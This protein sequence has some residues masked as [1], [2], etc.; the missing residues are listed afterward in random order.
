MATLADTIWPAEDGGFARLATTTAPGP[1]ARLG[2]VVAVRHDPVCV[3]LV[4]ATGG[5]P[6]L[7]RARPMEDVQVVEELDPATLAVRQSSGDLPLGPFWP[8]GVAALDDGGA[9]V[10][11]GRHAHRLDAD[12][13]ATQTRVLPAEAAHNSFVMLGDGTVA[14]KDLRRPGEVAST[15][16]L[17]DPDTLDE[18]AAPLVL[19][20]PSVS[21]LSADGELLVVIGV[22]ALHRYG[23]DGTRGVLVPLAAPL[24]YV[25]G[26]DQSFGWDPVI[27]D[28]HIWWMDNGDHQFVNGLTML[29]NGVAHGPVHLFRVGRE[30]DDVVAVEVSGLPGG[31]IT[32]PPLVDTARGVAIAYDS[33]NGVLAGFDIETL[34]PRWRTELATAQHLVLHADTGEVLADEF[35]PGVG[36]GLVVVDVT[37]GEVRCRVPVGSPAQS[38]VFGAPGSAGDAYYVSLS[39]VARVQFTS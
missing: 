19:P 39:T 29:G 18:R 28:R 27:T 11:Q 17:L 35:V 13:R 3:M 12:L 34:A 25:S 36:D 20:E 5:R 21:R 22:H 14:T 26:D 7:L 15:L 6:L 31:A 4:H 10:V 24:P 38:V 2:E 30:G 33:A 9:L 16:S 1:R 23:W 8:G 37:T 32:N